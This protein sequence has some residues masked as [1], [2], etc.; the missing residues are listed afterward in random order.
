[1]TAK[2]WA[3]VTGLDEKGVSATLT[4]GYQ[5][6]Y[7]VAIAPD[8][9]DITMHTPDLKVIGGIAAKV[10]PEIGGE[11][12]APPSASGKIGGEFGPELGAEATIIPSTDV[13][14]RVAPGKIQEVEALKVTMTN[15]RFAIDWDGIHLAVYNAVGPV[16]VRP[17]ARILVTTKAGV[18]QVVALGVPR[19][20]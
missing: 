19:Q 8:G 5:F 20:V 13:S 18:Y 11:I 10:S 1:M 17:F 12:G 9:V 3:R 7:P 16:T 6:G 4:L 14:F 15:P 2:T